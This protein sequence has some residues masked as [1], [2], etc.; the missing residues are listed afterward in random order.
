MDSAKIS[1]T[2]VEQ[3]RD[4]LYV[5]TTLLHQVLKT[6]SLSKDP[7]FLHQVQKIICSLNELSKL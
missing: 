5:L 2:E 3:L 1:P 4:E 7:K 6:P